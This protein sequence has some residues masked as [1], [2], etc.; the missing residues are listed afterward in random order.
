MNNFADSVKA[1][2][3]EVAAKE[4]NLVSGEM[5][6]SKPKGRRGAAKGTR[7]SPATEFKPGVSGNPSGRPKLK[8]ITDAM[9]AMLDQPFS[10]R[11]CG[12][13][14]KGMTNAEVLVAK[15][16]DAAIEKGDLRAAQEIADRVEGKVIQG[17]QHTGPGGGAVSFTS[18]TPEENE[19]RI[20]EL[21][22]K[23]SASPSG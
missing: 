12:G 19:R 13:K 22:Q 17:I 18:M 15:Q 6:E 3:R 14:Y 10:G 8:P 9:R 1:A 20:A 2:E 5:A 11:G 23:A 7:V 4:K 21:M 16:F